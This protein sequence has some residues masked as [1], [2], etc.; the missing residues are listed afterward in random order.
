MKLTGAGGVP[1]L[2]VVCFWFSVTVPS[3][4]W[5]RGGDSTTALSPS[6]H[7]IPTPYTPQEMVPLVNKFP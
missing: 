1:P 6:S 3:S 5:A 7:I 2:K 4:L